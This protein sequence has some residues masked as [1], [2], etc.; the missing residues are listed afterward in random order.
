[1]NE[2]SCENFLILLSETEARAKSNSHR[3]D[4]L[5]KQ[6]EALNRLAISVE[7]LAGEQKNLIE[8]IGSVDKK[9]GELEKLPKERWN[10]LI[11]YIIS[12]AS[13]SIITAVITRI[14]G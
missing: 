5:E 10:S 12:S 9:V 2:H 3:L 6:S 7:V 11:G 13:A 8:K 14:M 1:M 4:R